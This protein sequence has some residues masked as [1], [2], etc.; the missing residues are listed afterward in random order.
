MEMFFYRILHSRIGF[1]FYFHNEIIGFV[2]ITE[3]ILKLGMN[4]HI[5]SFFPWTP[6]FSKMVCWKKFTFLE[7]YTDLLENQT[8]KPRPI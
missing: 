4:E 2:N 3:S 1:L 8:T 5:L 7:K 6:G